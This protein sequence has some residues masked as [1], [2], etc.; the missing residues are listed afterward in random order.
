MTVTATVKTI[1]GETWLAFKLFYAIFFLTAFFQLLFYTTFIFLANESSVCRLVSLIPTYTRVTGL[2][3]WTISDDKCQA[4]CQSPFIA[5]KDM[6]ST[7][8]HEYLHVAPRNVIS[9]LSWILN[10]LHC[11]QTYLSSHL[12]RTTACTRLSRVNSSWLAN[13]GFLLCRIAA[14]ISE[15]PAY[16]R[17]T[18]SGGTSTSN[19]IMPVSNKIISPY[20]IICAAL[21]RPVTGL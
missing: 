18:K 4:P 2:R 5:R 1:V 20:D 7:F 3:A 15:K 19:T 11:W 14:L 8:G 21:Q 13:W 10:A 12:H 6:N 9:R 16:A 17:K